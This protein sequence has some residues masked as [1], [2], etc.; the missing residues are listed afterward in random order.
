MYS[1]LWLCYSDSACTSIPR[2]HSVTLKSEVDNLSLIGF[3]GRISSFTC[4]SDKHM[5]WV[6]FCTDHEFEGD[7]VQYII[8]AEDPPCQNIEKSYND[9]FHSFKS[10]PDM[11]CIGFR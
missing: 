1:S 6:K 5:G 7:C 11:V 9:K 3:G 8:P 4:V 10:T 2:D